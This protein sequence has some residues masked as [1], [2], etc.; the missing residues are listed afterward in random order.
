[1]LRRVIP[2][3]SPATRPVISPVSRIPRPSTR[4]QRAR[5]MTELVG[6][7]C[8][9]GR[10]GPKT[11]TRGARCGCGAA[12]GSSV[13]SRSR[14]RAAR[15]PRSTTRRFA[16]APRHGSVSA[17]STPRTGSACSSPTVASRARSASAACNAV[18]SRWATSATG[19][20]RRA[21]GNEYVPE[22]VV[23]LIRYAFETLHMHRLEA[24]IVPRNHPSRRVAEKLGLRDEGTAQRF[25]Q[26]RGIYEDHIRYAITLEEWQ[27]A[28]QRAPRRVLSRRAPVESHSRPRY[29]VGFG[30]RLAIEAVEH[31]A[32]L[33]IELRGLEDR[34]VP[35]ELEHDGRFHRRRFPRQP[36]AR[37]PAGRRPAR[38]RTR[39]DTPRPGSAS[40]ARRARRR[41][42]RCGAARA[43]RTSSCRPARSDGS[44]A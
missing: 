4:S 2:R 34:R 20:T 12:N 24:A 41:R 33:G 42:D 25:L 21:A 26:I 36:A 1:M 5:D 38:R 6:R 39:P 14:K 44:R 19:S 28:W 30:A 40:R 22:G 8:C 32:Q 16:R 23:L 35:D 18:R 10:C 3:S 31:S 29:V 11:G 43:R 27:R 7:G 13:G 9:S 37:Q 15:I 17:I